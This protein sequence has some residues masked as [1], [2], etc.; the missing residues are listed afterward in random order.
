MLW[1]LN[2]SEERSKAPMK[3]LTVDIRQASGRVLYGTIFQGQG[4]KLFAKGH[5][6]SE[7]DARLLQAEGLNEV[8][9]SR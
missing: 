4:K 5:T 7:Q 6:I 3:A 2:T 1:I 9:A 8:P